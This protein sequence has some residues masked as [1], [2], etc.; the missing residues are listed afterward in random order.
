MASIGNSGVGDGI[1][2]H[3]RVGLVGG[4]IDFMIPPRQTQNER[5]I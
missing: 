1:D 4:Y 5:W 2:V 3:C